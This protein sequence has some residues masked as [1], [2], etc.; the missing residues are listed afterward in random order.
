M[1]DP[2]FAIVGNDSDAQRRYFDTFRRSEHLGP[3]K[4]LLLAMLEDAIHLFQKY[5]GAR[6]R[7][8][9]E[10]FRD[11]VDWFMREGNHWLF[12]FENVC[13][14]LTLDRKC[15]RRGVLAS[16]GPSALTDKRGRR[17][18]HREAA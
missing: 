3:E 16:V 6:E 9:K 5:R 18:A 17:T 10:R 12:S 4:L 14:L 2:I 11:V 8:G 15:V 7:A 13:E 1:D